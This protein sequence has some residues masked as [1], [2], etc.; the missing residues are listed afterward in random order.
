MD[1]AAPFPTRRVRLPQGSVALVAT[2]LVVGGLLAGYR[3]TRMPVVLVVDG[4]TQQ[5]RTHRDT[6]FGL[7]LD[8]GIEVGGEDVVLYN[9]ADVTSALDTRVELAARIAVQRARSVRVTVD[10]QSV[11]LSTFSRSLESIL[12]EARV[13]LGPHDEVQ[14]EGDLSQQARD[15]DAHITV[16][17]ATPLTVVERGQMTVLHTT[18]AT[19]GEALTREGITLYL[20]DG[21]T[22]A[23]GK[24]VAEGMVVNIDRSTPVTVQSDGRLL[25]TRTHRETVEDVLSELG[26]VLTGMDYTT[27]TLASPVRA[28]M[29]I[30]VIRVRDRFLVEDEPIPFEVLWQPDPELEIDNHRLLQEGSPGILQRRV[31]VR[32]EDDQVVRRQVE[33]QYVAVPPKNKIQGFG[34]KVVVRTLDTPAGPIEYWR[35]Y[36]MLATS[37]S[38][39]TAGVSPTNPY[40]GRT[41][42]GLP[43]GYGIVAVDPTWIPLGSNVYVPGYGTALAGDTGGKIKGKRIDLGYDDASLVLWYSWVDVYVLTPVPANIDYSLNIF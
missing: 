18:A 6:V 30:R 2:V 29:A 43:A 36:R 40:Y 31:R 34:T 14:I 37:Y 11:V 7:L 15:E 39:S 16:K 21:V 42:I 23:L 32:Y 8:Q 17:R 12:A 38:A 5:V 20:A 19:I 41:R 3:S 9:G 4:Q 10:G 28:D 35:V 22:P 26:L 25:R 27:P 13:S 33:G 24:P 1:L